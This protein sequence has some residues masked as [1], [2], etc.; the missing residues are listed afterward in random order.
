M[1]TC[2]C[3][4]GSEGNCSDTATVIS[5]KA[6]ASSSPAMVDLG[7]AKVFEEIKEMRAEIEL[8]KAENKDLKLQQKISN[9]EE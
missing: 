4:C 2:G 5:T 8:L 9:E 7:F 3:G 6:L 1:A